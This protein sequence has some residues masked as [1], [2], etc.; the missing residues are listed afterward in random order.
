MREIKFLTGHMVYNPAYNQILQTKET[1]FVKFT[2]V[3]K[4]TKKQFSE[5]L[6]DYNNFSLLIGRQGKVPFNNELINSRLI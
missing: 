6:V 2:C 1:Y 5:V 3:S 4:Y